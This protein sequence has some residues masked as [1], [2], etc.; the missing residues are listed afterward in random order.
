MLR[1]RQNRAD[2]SDQLEYMR[3][4]SKQ[5]VQKECCL[6][7][8]GSWQERRSPIIELALYSVSCLYDDECLPWPRVLLGKRAPTSRN[9]AEYVF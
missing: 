3:S 4:P 1:D 5:E 9:Y 7:L 2:P 8:G 6:L